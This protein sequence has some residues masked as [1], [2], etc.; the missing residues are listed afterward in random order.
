[1]NKDFHLILDQAA[2]LRVPMPTAAAAFQMNV[3]RAAKYPDEDYS[4]VIAQMEDWSGIDVYSRPRGETS[5]EQ[6]T[7]SSAQSAA[8]RRENADGATNCHGAIVKVSPE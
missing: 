3:A 8:L 5:P 4:G 7:K 1:M 6:P 2:A